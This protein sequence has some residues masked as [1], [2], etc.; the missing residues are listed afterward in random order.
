VLV[1]EQRTEG[2]EIGAGLQLSPNASSILIGWGLGPALAASA[3]APEALAIRRWGEARSYA[4]M[5]FGQ[6]PDGAPFWV[7]LR[8]D[9][10]AALRDAAGRMAGVRIETGLALDRIRRDGDSLTATLARGFDRIEVE[11]DC[12]I[13]A[14]GQR[15]MARRLLGDARDLDPPGWEAWRSLIPTEAA[16]EVFRR[17]AVNLWLGRDAHAVHYPVAAGRLVNLVVIGRSRADAEGWSRAGDAAA[18][19][20]AAGAAQPLRDLIGAAPGWAVWTLRDRS[21]STILAKG[22]A[23]LVGDA[24]H[25]VLPFMAQGAAMA[26][27]DA[28]VLAHALPSP[29]NFKAPAIEAGL[30]AYARAREARIHAVFKAGRANAFAYHLG[31][32]MAWL[33]DARIAQ[34]GPEGMRRRYSWLYDWRATGGGL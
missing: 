11:T 3:V 15:S 12:L 31:G 7:T 18:L 1:A 20:G 30:A 17:P 29:E 24:A 16:P 34:L 9:L 33:R 4:S 23:A 28:A 10:H 26:I 13:G 22:A 25:P 5:P 19:P 8:A 27:E 6:R 14:D 21:P 32:P 2:G